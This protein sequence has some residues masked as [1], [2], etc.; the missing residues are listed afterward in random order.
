MEEDST[1]DESSDTSH[2][3]YC[4]L[5]IDIGTTSVKASIITT[6]NN[7][8][9]AHYVKDTQA[10]IPPKTDFG[11]NKQDVSKIISAMNFCVSK[12][13]KPLLSQVSAIGICCQMHGVTCWTHTSKRQAWNIVEKD[14]NVRY[15]VIP[16]NISPLY[17]WQDTRCDKSF[18]DRLPRPHSHINIA[19]G[20]GIPTLFWLTKYE[21]QLLKQFNC[22][23]TIGDFVV[24]MLCNLDKPVMSEQNAASW[25]YYNCLTGTWNTDILTAYNFP[26][27]LLPEVA[28]AGTTAGYLTENWHSIPAGTAIGVAMGDIQCSVLSSIQSNKDAIL[29]ISTS[30]QITYVANK[31]QPTGGP[32]LPGPVEYIPYFN[33]TYVAIAASLNGGNCLAT[34][35][36]TLQQWAL[37]LGYSVPQSKVWDKVLYLANEDTTNS[38]LKIR[39]TC[40]GERHN[41]EM[42]SSVYNITMNNL[43]LGTVFK[44]L[45]RGLIDNLHDMMPSRLLHEAKISRIL[46][47][48]KGLIR[49]PILQKS[50][51]EVFQL[52]L[53]LVPGGEAATG[54]AIAMSDVLEG[55]VSNLSRRSETG[56][57]NKLTTDEYY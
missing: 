22:A 18:L 23:G 33:H 25:G 35:V 17:T 37:E 57:Q 32:P 5:G 49:N 12:L 3:D 53:E 6:K 26:M 38:D 41:P 56:S 43:Q 8:V 31:F 21:S 40:L 52:P 9:E 20:Y 16:E 55:S 51:E 13:P 44:S 45:C 42:K 15:D 34:F 1:S 48:G 47:N 11:E 54:A 7:Q 14:K 50:I 46:G 24:A 2:M 29:N 19:T 36:K 4:I 39:P 30:A 28:P 27:H 10:N